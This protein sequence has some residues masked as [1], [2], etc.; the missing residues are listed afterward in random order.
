MSTPRQ[1]RVI[2]YALSACLL[3]LIGL[4][5]WRYSVSNSLP[6]LFEDLPLAEAPKTFPEAQYAKRFRWV[7]LNPEAFDRAFEVGGKLKLNFFGDEQYLTTIVG[8]Q[9][10]DKTSSTAAALLDDNPETMAIFSRSGK[11]LYAVFTLSDM[12]QVVVSHVGGRAYSIA[13]IDPASV[14]KCMPPP[15]VSKK[16]VAP[17]VSLR[18]GDG[19]AVEPV[20]AGAN[21]EEIQRR[22]TPDQQMLLTRI[23]SS[24]E[25][26][27][28]LGRAFEAPL[29]PAERPATDVNIT[30]N[31][32]AANLLMR[33]HRETA[34]T[35][36]AAPFLA[37]VKGYSLYGRTSQGV[38]ADPGMASQVL[39]PRLPST[40]YIDVLFL[41]TAAAEAKAGTKTQVYLRVNA[42][43][44]QLNGIFA[45]SGIPMEI[46]A[47][48]D[49]TQYASDRYVA[50][51]R[52]WEGSSVNAEPADYNAGLASSIIPAALTP[53]STLAIPRSTMDALAWNNRTTHIPEG[54]GGVHSA[55]MR[56]PGWTAWPNYSYGE[57][58]MGVAN[59][60]P[61]GVSSL[62]ASTDW[63]GIGGG[64]PPN[65]EIWFGRY[66]P[67]VVNYVSG[68]ALDSALAWLSEVPPADPAAAANSW[69]MAGV[70]RSNGF[71][72]GDQ[73][74]GLDTPWINHIHANS[75][76]DMFGFTASALPDYSL[77]YSWNLLPNTAALNT[78]TPPPPDY[79]VAMVWSELN[80]AAV[81][82]FLW[83]VAP[84]YAFASNPAGPVATTQ[85]NDANNLALSWQSTDGVNHLIGPAE[86]TPDNV[87]NSTIIVPLGD[88]DYFLRAW[89]SPLLPESI[90]SHPYHAVYGGLNNASL[91][92]NPTIVTDANAEYWNSDIFVGPTFDTRFYKQNIRG[93]LASTYTAR[94]QNV[95]GTGLL[96]APLR[97]NTGG[98]LRT[99][100]WGADVYPYTG[101][102]ESGQVA[103]AWG[104]RAIN[105]DVTY[106]RPYITGFGY[107]ANPN[108]IF[109]RRPGHEYIAGQ[110]IFISNVSNP[111]DLAL[112]GYHRILTVD[113]NWFTIANPGVTVSNSGTFEVGNSWVTIETTPTIHG[114]RNGTVVRICSTAGGA[115]S[116]SATGTLY[117]VRVLGDPATSTQFQVINP[118]LA[119]ATSG[120]IPVGLDPNGVLRG[121]TGFNTPSL[122]L[123]TL[124]NSVLPDS[125]TVSG[126]FSQRF[127]DNRITIGQYNGA[128]G[129]R[130]DTLSALGA[131]N[132]ARYPLL[133][134]ET[135]IDEKPDVI[136]LLD[137]SSLA[138]NYAGISYPFA[139]EGRTYNAVTNQNYNMPS[140]SP[141]LGPG[142]AL[143][144][145]PS[146]GICQNNAAACAVMW[147]DNSFTCAVDIVQGALNYSFAHEMGHI[148]GC[149]HGYGDVIPNVVGGLMPNDPTVVFSKFMND[150]TTRPSSPNTAD[151]AGADTFHSMGV[152]IVGD[153]GKNYHTIMAYPRT[154]TS[155]RIPYFSSPS[156]FF[157]GRQLNRS[158]D[159][160]TSGLAFPSED[161]NNVKCVSIIGP[162]VARYRD[163]NGTGR[164]APTFVVGSIPGSGVPARINQPLPDISKFVT[165][166][167]PMKTGMGTGPVP[168]ASKVP[169]TSTKATPGATGAGVATSGA[170]SNPAS[171]G[172]SVTV[173]VA[174][175]RPPN[176]N[177]AKA[178]MIQGTSKTVRGDN[179]AA[180]P[181][182]WEGPYSKA[183]QGRSIWWYLD[184]LTEGRLTIKTE[185]SNFDTVLLVFMY[186][187]GKF[188]PVAV[189]DNAGNGISW[190]QVAV[191]L[192]KGT[193]YYIGVDGAGGAEGQVVLNVEQVA[194][195]SKVAA[196]GTSATR[197]KIRGTLAPTADDS[198]P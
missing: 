80:N 42:L 47:V 136:C 144:E 173:P 159:V 90:A 118:T 157:R 49:P 85:W 117:Q 55:S 9:I 189:N 161:C 139:R 194:A 91:T 61:Q 147:R 50:R 154:A 114:F 13:E 14:G 110:R 195:P 125:P 62:Y 65:P 179:K 102:T 168:D 33:D 193:R 53:P 166:M 63:R 11:S 15:G 127:L 82:P 48:N 164:N 167:S 89:A 35:E 156:L 46:R 60:R 94:I 104:E 183:F 84:F 1:K 41:Y 181:E 182:T 101:F 21:L 43:V 100:A 129:L 30:A 70:R 7:K 143:H 38:K 81:P 18:T 79:G 88:D 186:A 92:L 174:I 112:T 165:G 191:N 96:R 184:G 169:T 151:G 66:S 141:T 130:M 2:R 198:I 187:N 146:D 107:T 5:F 97:R 192:R 45:R 77:G 98:H 116:G 115:F 12:R 155:L 111:P 64:G 160:L 108:N 106:T 78:A 142:H 163:A 86:N 137:D 32:I 99:G 25:A 6:E 128:V 196:P 27:A 153:D 71:I 138:N 76:N 171:T 135:L 126:V 109:I 29:K 152:H 177:I 148:L 24:P 54:I 31:P 178:F 69:G 26:A 75:W 134:T 162:I 36:I 175:A 87:R 150:Q 74:W 121:T 140:P 145:Y 105:H 10:H 188:L 40:E 120:S 44:T 113:S 67:T 172:R 57:A 122:A 23:L 19:N 8:K 20:G 52:Y 59:S 185:G 93:I 149:S 51:S 190:S 4:G 180:T 34:G 103:G 73:Y 197:Q 68:G 16:K 28:K 17:K 170:S 176:D 58:A 124:A 56:K 3:L 37:Q 83:R 132:T 72:Y 95:W 131:H 119:S 123:A 158:T 22:L 39:Y 133:H